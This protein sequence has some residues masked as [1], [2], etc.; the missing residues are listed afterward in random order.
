METWFL[1]IAKAVAIAGLL[2]GGADLARADVV[3][4]QVDN[5]VFDPEFVIVNLGDTVR[6]V[7]ING[8]HSTTSYEGLWD[9]GLLGP[10]D[11][12][13]YTFTATGQFD[14]FCSIHVDCCQMVG[15]VYVLDNPLP[16]PT[17]RP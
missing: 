5:N 1:P 8:L 2:V 13:E 10:G 16:R 4:V 17:A 15:T 14:Y 7:W 12:F 9:S 11:D 3:E 6:W